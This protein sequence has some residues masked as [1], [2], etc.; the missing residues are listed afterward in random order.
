MNN[1]EKSSQGG[2]ENVINVETTEIIQNEVSPNKGP[3][4]KVFASPKKL[5]KKKKSSSDDHKLDAAWNTLQYF[6]KNKQTKDQFETFG[7]YI[8]EKLRQMDSDSCIHVKKS[9]NDIIYEAE[10]G[11]YRSFHQRQSNLNFPSWISTFQNSVHSSPSSLISHSSPGFYISQPSSG[12]YIYFRTI[13]IYYTSIIRV[14]N[15]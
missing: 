10:L 13:T 11:N 5:F 12:S 3:K 15:V 6:S 8:A 1:A 14:N 9:I 4:R 7:Q 2:I